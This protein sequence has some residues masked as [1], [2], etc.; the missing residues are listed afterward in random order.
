M[1]S[2]H[3]TNKYDFKFVT[4][5][6]RDEVGKGYPVAFFICNREDETSLTDF[7]YAI[8]CRCSADFHVNALMTDDDNTGWA[9]FKKVF[10]EAVH[11]LLCKW[12]VHRSWI[13][14]L[15]QLYRN[16]HL[17]QLELY[18]TMVVIMEEKDPNNFK[19]LVDAFEVTFRI[20]GKDFA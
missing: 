5:V 6:V 13:R 14:K 10:G 15:R 18:R 3:S 4:V 8:K 9:A 11:H 2:T 16:D 20:R 17:L 19:I 7:L 12:H 1:D